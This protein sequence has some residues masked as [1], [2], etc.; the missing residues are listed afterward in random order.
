MQ[1]VYIII[2][3]IYI[4]QIVYIIIYIIY[5]LYIYIYVCVCVCMCV[6]VYYCNV[7]II[8]QS[9]GMFIIA[10]LSK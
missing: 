5:I 6:C 2:Y 7:K 10:V 4:M 9:T 1:I 8:F 3:I